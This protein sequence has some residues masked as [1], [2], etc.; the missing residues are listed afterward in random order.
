M[1]GLAG[2]LMD[3]LKVHMEKLGKKKL[4]KKKL[5]PH[6]SHQIAIY[7]LF[8]KKFILLCIKNL[9]LSCLF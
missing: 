9:V 3:G 4:V 7:C 6:L 2:V 8:P 5:D 1:L